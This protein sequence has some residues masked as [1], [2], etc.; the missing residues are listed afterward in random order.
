MFS[1]TYKRIEGGGARCFAGIVERRLRM[2]D[3]AHF[4]GLHVIQKQGRGSRNR[5]GI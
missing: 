3:F 4:V 1:Y 5:V 2:G